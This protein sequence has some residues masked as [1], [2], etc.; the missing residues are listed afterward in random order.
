MIDPGA[1]GTL[2]I[3]QNAERF[4]AERTSEAKADPVRPRGRTSIRT[5]AARGLRALAARL[6]HLDGRAES[7]EAGPA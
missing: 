7:G 6:D 5:A 3:R 1:L 2:L 4:D